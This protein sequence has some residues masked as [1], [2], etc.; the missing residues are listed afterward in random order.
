M[1][2]N[3]RCRID[4]YRMFSYFLTVWRFKRS[5][6]PKEDGF[7]YRSEPHAGAVFVTRDEK[8]ILIKKFR[9]SYW[10]LQVL[11]WI[12]VIF[13]MSIGGIIL[14][15][16][17]A[18]DEYILGFSYVIAIG[19]TF[20][21]FATRRRLFDIPKQLLAGRETVGSKRSRMEFYRDN[22]VRQSWSS[23]IV[24]GAVLS[25]LAWLTY[26]V[27]KT[28]GLAP[29]FWVACFALFFGIWALGVWFKYQL[30]DVTPGE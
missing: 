15:D 24:M 28:T 3:R 23:K 6:E 12:S 19:V 2:L 21:V 18:S 1:K 26:P 22:M 29:F 27:T 4:G 14:F 10:N 30:R 5:F 11:L 25:G 7:L 9:R 8:E 16:S 17:N 20:G 13:V